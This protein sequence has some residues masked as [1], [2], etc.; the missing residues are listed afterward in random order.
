MVSV[1][2]FW[3]TYT[4]GDFMSEKEIKTAIKEKKLIVGSKSVFDLMKKSALDGVFYAENC[5]EDVLAQ[6]KHYSGVSNIKIKE[7]KGDSEKLGELC[8][9]PFNILVVGLKK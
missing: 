4:D 3:V 5:P 6:L 1:E 8:A 2:S 7:F 9:K